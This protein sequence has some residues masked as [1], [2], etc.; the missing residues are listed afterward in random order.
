MQTP[1]HYARLHSE[2]LPDC[3]GRLHC[4][5]LWQ[6]RAEL[7]NQRE[8]SHAASVAMRQLSESLEQS[9]QAIVRSSKRLNEAINT[10]LSRPATAAEPHVDAEHEAQLAAWRQRTDAIK[11]H[12]DSPLLDRTRV[13][14]CSS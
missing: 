7:A 5:P 10:A 2:R 1:V 13:A 4:G 9:Q 8:Q 11:Q 14:P 6:L 3:L 12:E